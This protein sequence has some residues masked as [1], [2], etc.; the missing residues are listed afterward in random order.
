MIERDRGLRGRDLGVDNAEESESRSKK[1]T[2]NTHVGVV[3][4]V[5]EAAKTHLSSKRNPGSTFLYVNSVFLC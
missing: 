5:A 3:G 1:T 2:E 4:L